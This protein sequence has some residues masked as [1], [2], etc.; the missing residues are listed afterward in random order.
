M[1]NNKKQTAHV[2]D[3]ECPMNNLIDRLTKIYPSVS[4]NLD[5]N[6]DFEEKV[7]NI[8]QQYRHAF[9]KHGIIMDIYHSKNVSFYYTL[10]Y[11]D[12]HFYSSKKE[13]NYEFELTAQMACIEK[14]FELCNEK[15]DDFYKYGESL[16]ISINDLQR[17]K[18]LSKKII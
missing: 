12:F 11:K 17:L 5:L 10:A 16:G 3:E 2:V 1:K 13:S 7:P 9:K 8:F 14:A 18:M 6:V 15:I 4:S